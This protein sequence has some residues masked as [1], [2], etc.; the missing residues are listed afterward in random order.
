MKQLLENFDRE[1]LDGLSIASK[2]Q[3]NNTQVKIKN[4][5]ISGLGGSGI[6]G[7]IAYSLLSNKLDVPYYVNKGYFLPNYIDENSLVIICSYSGNT[8]ESIHAFK[9]AM[10]KNAVIVCIT[11]G[12]ELLNLAKN[13]NYNH[14]VI[15]SGRPPRASLGYSLIQLFATLVKYNLIEEE[16]LETIEQASQFITKNQ[17]AIIE[18]SAIVCDAIYD[19]LP[20][21]YCEETIEPIA[22]RWKQQL[23]ENS[24]MLCWHNVYP[25]MNHNE[26]VGWREQNHHLALIM[27]KT[28]DEFYR[29]QARM[30]LNE[31]IYK[32]VTNSITHITAKGNNRIEKAFYLIHYGDWLSYH[33]AI[34]RGYDPMEIDVLIKLKNDLSNIK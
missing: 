29:N 22:I 19:K 24:K 27:F 7:S 6:G 28:G 15:P 11:S 2:T 21:I 9:E 13:C 23:N 18:E 10:H 33:L 34:K 4:I 14:I 25:E 3:F 8:E 17:A 30:D 20:V 12:G 1:L 31:V 26:L 5:V 16:I 32:N